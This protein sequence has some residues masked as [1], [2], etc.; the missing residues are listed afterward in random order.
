MIY[1]SCCSLSDVDCRLR[2]VLGEEAIYPLTS[3]SDVSSICALLEM[4][5]KILYIILYIHR[6]GHISEISLGNLHKFCLFLAIIRPE[7]SYFVMISLVGY[8]RKHIIFCCV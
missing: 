4:S 8:T 3:H 7:M 6:N 2:F 5:H 1:L